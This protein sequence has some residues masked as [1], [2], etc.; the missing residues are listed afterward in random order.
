MNVIAKAMVAAGSVDD[1]YAIRVINTR[2]NCSVLL[3]MESR[4]VPAL[5]AQ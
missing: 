3:K 5:S 4:T 1:P 2:M